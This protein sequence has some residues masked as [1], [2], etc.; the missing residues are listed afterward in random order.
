MQLAYPV[1]IGRTG[2]TGPCRPVL[3]V[4]SIQLHAGQS[5]LRLYYAPANKVADGTTWQN[6]YGAS[7]LDACQSIRPVIIIIIIC[8]DCS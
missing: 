2:F 7:T 4:M 5:R 3:L 8:S 1:D 6:P